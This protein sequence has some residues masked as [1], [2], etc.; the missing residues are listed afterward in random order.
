MIRKFSPD[1]GSPG[2]MRDRIA[3]GVRL[4]GPVI[5][6]VIVLF[7]ASFTPTSPAPERGA[8]RDADLTIGMLARCP[9]YARSPDLYLSVPPSTGPTPTI[10]IPLRQ[11]PGHAPNPVGPFPSPS[12]GHVGRGRPAPIGRVYQERTTWFEVTC[13]QAE[14]R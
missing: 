8:S 1:R 3:P 7:G 10:L 5:F 12:L 4:A 13:V 2:M 14:R 6:C 11:R 9:D